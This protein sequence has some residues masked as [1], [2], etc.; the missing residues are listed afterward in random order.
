[1]PTAR[2]RDPSFRYP[3]A[4][5][6]RL[7]VATGVCVLTEEIGG[8]RPGAGHELIIEAIDEVMGDQLFVTPRQPGP[9]GPLARAARA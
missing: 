7:D 9:I 6:V 3:D 4:H 8:S 5:R 1:V 2:D